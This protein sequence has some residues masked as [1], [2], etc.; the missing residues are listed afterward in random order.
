MNR[1][2]GIYNLIDEK[3]INKSIENVIYSGIDFNTYGSPKG[4]KELRK[5]IAEF[6][7]K[8]WN[9]NGDDK[10]ILITT[11]SQQSIN[12]IASSLF[13]EGDTILV[14]Q[15]TYFG[16]LDVFKRMNVNLVGVNLTE[17]G[18]AEKELRNKIKR[19]KPKA[20]YVVPT[21]NN[22]TGYAWS[23][24]KRVSFLK[25]VNKYNVLVIEDDPY[26]YIN[27]TEYNYLTLYEING[28]KNVIYLGTFSKLISPSI[29]V[30]YIICD[31]ITMSKIYEY[32]KSFDLCTSLF[33]QYVILD[34]LNNNNLLSIIDKKIS[35]YKKLLKKSLE[36]LNDVEYV[37]KAKGGLFYLVKFKT[38]IDSN[39]YEC[40][41]NYFIDERHN[42]MTRINIC[43]YK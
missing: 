15:P 22:P 7:R 18:F 43:S 12:L 27:F 39:S 17:D 41:N 2:L 1:S 3:G 8:A 38:S 35:L 21:F 24:E 23:N 4:L 30:G 19:Y 34:Y 14:E 40:I 25:L 32:K 6:L 36:E 5:K 13:K 31:D 42:D 9:Y 37:S 28:G 29:N 11:G 10:N 20:I 16:A 33:L 26:R